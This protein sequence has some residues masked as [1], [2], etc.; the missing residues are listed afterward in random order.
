MFLFHKENNWMEYLL[1]IY[2]VPLFFVRA[3][4][5]RPLWLVEKKAQNWCTCAYLKLSIIG[6]W[7]MRGAP[8]MQGWE[9]SENPLISEFFLQNI[10]VIFM[11]STNV[12]SIFRAFSCCLFSSLNMGERFTI[13]QSTLKDWLVAI[14]HLIWFLQVNII[15]PILISNNHREWCL[16]SAKLV[17]LAYGIKKLQICC[18]VEDDKVRQRASC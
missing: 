14:S 6:D 13:Q 2:V 8:N 1:F 16:F 5:N 10:Q 3:V 15:C 17:P 4:I 12:F 18:V 11:L 9:F 7:P